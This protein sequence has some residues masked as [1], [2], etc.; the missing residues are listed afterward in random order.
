M[1]IILAQTEE[2]LG[3]YFNTIKEYISKKKIEDLTIELK[4]ETNEVKKREI[5]KQIVDI[6]MKECI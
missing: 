1:N 3:E 5:A 4:K 2:E 6:K